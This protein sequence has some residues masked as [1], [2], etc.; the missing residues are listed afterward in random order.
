MLLRIFSSIQRKTL[1]K[2]ETG[3]LIIQPHQIL[4]R[5]SGMRSPVFI[6][7]R[8]VSSSEMQQCLLER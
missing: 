5:D 4:R 8:N 3:E 1:D 6:Q 2:A 7:N